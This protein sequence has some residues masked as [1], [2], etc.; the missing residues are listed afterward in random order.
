M[1]TTLVNNVVKSS[2]IKKK[3]HWSL[4]NRKLQRTQSVRQIQKPGDGKEKGG[5]KTWHKGEL[6][7]VPKLKW[8]SWIFNYQ[9]LL[10][11]WFH[12]YGTA[13]GSSSSW[14]RQVNVSQLMIFVKER[15]YDGVNRL[16]VESAIP[17]ASIL[18]VGVSQNRALN[19]FFKKNDIE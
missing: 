5:W 11:V 17:N 9:F 7:C 18:N 15:N 6:Y 2:K 16:W 13:F 8:F 14:E 10:P 3:C 4:D 1:G 12:V 19:I